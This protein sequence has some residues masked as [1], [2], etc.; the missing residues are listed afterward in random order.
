MCVEDINAFGFIK[1]KLVGTVFTTG[2][3][4][5]FNTVVEPG[6]R[7]IVLIGVDCCEIIGL[8]VR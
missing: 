7:S 1:L 5:S 8:S 4:S 6:N 3:G 2:L